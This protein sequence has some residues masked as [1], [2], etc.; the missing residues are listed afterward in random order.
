MVL[1]SPTYA[2]SLDGGGNL[3]ITQQVASANDNLIFF[4]SGS[5]YS[6]IDTGGLTFDT[7]TGAN[8][9]SISG[10]GTSTLKI[11][12]TAVTSISVVLGTGTNVFNLTGAGGAG[13]APISVNTGITNGDQVNITG[14]ILDSGAITLTS[15]AI[16]ETGSGSI[17]TTGTLTTSSATGITLGGAN[18][19]GSFTRHQH[20]QRQHQP[21]QCGGA[22][23]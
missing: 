6:L 16:S 7:P 20:D 1:S 11:S 19:V 9:G 5:S 2:E 13:A 15:N 3:T 17:S 21:D 14:A 18:T 10:T 4:L 23:R 22:E 12:S 8:S